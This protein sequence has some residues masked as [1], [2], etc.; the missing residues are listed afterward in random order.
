MGV[1]AVQILTTPAR[2]A[3]ATPALPKTRPRVVPPEIDRHRD[4]ALLAPGMRGRYVMPRRQRLFVEGLSLHVHQRGNNRQDIFHDDRDRTMFFGVLVEWAARYAVHVHVWTF[5]DNHFHLIVTPQTPDGVARTM[6][7]VGRRYVPYFNR[8]HSRTGG[9]W[10][11]R[12]SAHVI[13]TE[14]YWYRCLRYVELN[15]VRA[16]IAGTPHEH[17]WSSYHAHAFGAEDALV[18]HHDLY[19][20]LGA[21]PSKRQNAHRALCHSAL[22]DC[23]VAAIRSALRTGGYPV[24]PPQPAPAGPAGGGAGVRPTDV[25]RPAMAD[26]AI[27]TA[28][29]MSLTAGRTDSIV[30][31]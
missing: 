23:E 9:L 30:D 10:E 18:T 27:A 21:T 17:R 6:Q 22:S 12:Y 1:R 4:V 11:G 8:R 31:P 5:M 26:A 14:A 2:R 19:L 25:E 28:T 13:D 29:M 24:E 20:R 16:N 15:P 7:Q 3:A